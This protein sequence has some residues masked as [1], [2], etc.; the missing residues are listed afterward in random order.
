[1]RG[2][3]VFLIVIANVIL[4]ST[5]FQYFRIFGVK[6]DFCII[7]IVSYALLQ[8]STYGS[9]IG[10]GSG[11]LLDMMFG[12]TI[13]LNAF[14]YMLTGYFIGRLHDNVFKDSFIPAVLFNFAAVFISQH[15]YL[16]LAYFSNNF[17]QTTT[18]YFQML[19]QV[20][21]P[22]AV[23]TALLGGLIY[24]YIYRLDE[25]RFMKRRIY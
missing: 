25:K 23:Y 5:L 17:A 14:A 12:R 2:I 16:L 9:M 19:F 7:L 15:L 1:M 8:G 20:I 13:G 6:P 10:L 3:V 21:L 11:L 22:Q 24:R 4:E 18:T